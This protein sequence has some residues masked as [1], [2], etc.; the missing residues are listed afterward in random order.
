[1]KKNSQTH[2]PMKDLFYAVER[3]KLRKTLNY[4]KLITVIMI[5][6]AFSLTI[7]L[8]IS[9][10]DNNLGK[11]YFSKNIKSEIE[12]IVH[13]DGDIEVVKHVFNNKELK[14]VFGRDSSFD[15][16]E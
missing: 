9:D 4:L 14:K 11:L 16:F 7:I 8:F 2:Q 1:M 12:T 3:M 13:N 5:I 10:Q 15:C 6:L